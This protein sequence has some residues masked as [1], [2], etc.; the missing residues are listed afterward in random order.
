MALSH[1]EDHYIEVVETFKA[2]HEA[3]RKVGVYDWGLVRE[4]FQRRLVIVE[5]EYT[6]VGNQ[7][8]HYVR[9]G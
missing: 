4:F 5:L 3:L 6:Q 7:H 9:S 8:I 2:S 1:A